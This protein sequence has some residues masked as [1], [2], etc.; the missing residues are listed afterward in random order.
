MDARTAPFITR[1]VLGALAGFVAFTSLPSLA[2]AE[3]DASHP[4]AGETAARPSATARAPHPLSNETPLFL[5]VEFGVSASFALSATLFT[6]GASECRWCEPGGL[7]AS[8][9]SAIYLHDS[10][11]PALVSHVTSLG[12]APIAALSAVI[13]P[14]LGADKPAY[15]IEDTIVIVDTVLFVSGVGD[16]TKNGSGRERPAFHYGRQNETEATPSARNKSFFSLDTAW[17]F[18]ACATSATLSA[19]RGYWTAP[20]VAGAGAVLG[21]TTG[22]LRMAA[23][24]HWLTDVV[25]GAAIGTGFGVAM[26]LILHPRADRPPPAIVLPV[27]TPT[28]VGF[29]ARGI[30]N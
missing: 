6:H 22:I 24:M 20:Y 13:F 7:D 30:W 14:A 17:A 12:L 29:G 5:G 8:V 25:A 11:T 1:S 18:T 4:P 23:D 9:R 28:F 27:M 3:E 26:P 15:A 21:V 2:R 10:K 16:F 19:E